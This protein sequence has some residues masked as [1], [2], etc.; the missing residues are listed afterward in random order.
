MKE[1][2]DCHTAVFYAAIHFDPKAPL[3]SKERTLKLDPGVTIVFEI[4]DNFTLRNAD[5]F[6]KKSEA[7][8]KGDK[9]DVNLSQ[10]DE[11]RKIE[12]DMAESNAESDK[13]IEEPAKTRKKPG[14]KPKKRW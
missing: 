7:E 13:P 3:D 4:S 12:K 9:V 14:P 6:K 1:L 10:P 2:W 8:S 11:L 5:D